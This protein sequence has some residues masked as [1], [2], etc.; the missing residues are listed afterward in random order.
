MILAPLNVRSAPS[1]NGDIIGGLKPGLVVRVSARSEDGEWWRL[2]DPGSTQ[3]AWISARPDLTSTTLVPTPVPQPGSS[4][5]LPTTSAE[6]TVPEAGP[7]QWMLEGAELTNPLSKV[8][9]LPNGA[10][11]LAFSPDGT[12]LVA[13]TLAGEVQI[14]N[15]A[16]TTLKWQATFT[17][18]VRKVQF[19]PTGTHVAAVSFDGGA[20]LWETETGTPIAE[21]AYGYWVYGLDF[22]ADGQWVAT[23]SFDTNFITEI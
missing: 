21:H 6:I 14:W 2:S 5:A 18:S 4:S 8:L 19:S 1:L 10:E 16:T 13:G 15:L 7:P 22:S 17:E 3:E 12:L 9:E 20:R 23:G 11:T